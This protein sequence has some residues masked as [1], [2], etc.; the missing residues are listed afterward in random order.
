MNGEEVKITIRGLTK[1]ID[2]F[3][4]KKLINFE[5]TSI[6]ESFI[7]D[8]I[9]TMVVDVDHSKL[10]KNSDNFNKDYS[11]MILNLNKDG[12][13]FDEELSQA[14]RHFG[15]FDTYFQFYY[16]HTN[17]DVYEPLLDYLRTKGFDFSVETYEHSIMLYIIIQNDF[18]FDDKTLEEDGFNTDTIVFK[19]R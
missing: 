16:E 13:G 15:M 18:I 5:I 19:R 11:N 12:S 2:I 8:R 3:V 10:W 1:F 17:L 4:F 7:A 9:I 6:R 14:A